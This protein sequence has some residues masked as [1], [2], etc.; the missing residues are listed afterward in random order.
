MSK[1]ATHDEANVLSRN[2]SEKARQVPYNQPKSK[3][4][5]KGGFYPCKQ[6]LKR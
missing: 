4:P 6:N 1:P 3:K 2:W 5:P